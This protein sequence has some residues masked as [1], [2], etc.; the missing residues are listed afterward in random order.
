GR[1]RSPPSTV[2]HGGRYRNPAGQATAGLRSIRR[3]P[4][5]GSP[6]RARASPLGAGTGVA[7]TPAVPLNDVFAGVVNPAGIEIRITCWRAYGLG[8]WSIVVC[9]LPVLPSWFG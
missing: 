1:P 3:R 4:I 5:S 6:T 2:A 7:V 9:R 8:I